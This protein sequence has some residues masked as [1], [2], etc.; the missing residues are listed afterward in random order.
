MRNLNLWDL[1]QT[2]CHSSTRSS[3]R[4]TCCS[5]SETAKDET[6]C[7]AATAR[8]RVYGQRRVSGLSH[9]GYHVIIFVALAGITI[10]SV[11][12]CASILQAAIKSMARAAG[13]AFEQCVKWMESRTGS[14]KSYGH[15]R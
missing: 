4:I 9:R 10:L 11:L 5:A 14:E 8:S 15:T 7:E 13:H 6:R 2:D 12:E 3:E 1:F